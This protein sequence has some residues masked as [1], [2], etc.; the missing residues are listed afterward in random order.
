MI[1]PDPV[2]PE[3]LRSL[4]D[5][6]AEKIRPDQPT[7]RDGVSAAAALVHVPIRTFRRWLTA[8]GL[9]AWSAV[10]LLRLSVINVRWSAKIAPDEHGSNAPLTPTNE[11]QQT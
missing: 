3:Y 8:D 6:L 4:C 11:S 2:P 1:T 9:P 10:E 5:D 7:V